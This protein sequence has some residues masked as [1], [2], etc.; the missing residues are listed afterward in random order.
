MGNSNQSVQEAVKR[1]LGLDFCQ[2]FLR[3][4]HYFVQ[5]KKRQYIAIALYNMQ[6]IA[7]YISACGALAAGS[8]NVLAD[9]TFNSKGT[10]L[11]ADRIGTYL[12]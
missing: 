12:F 3:K 8:L 11:T 6:R 7:T 1:W 9:F 2:E 4:I 5:F 10:V